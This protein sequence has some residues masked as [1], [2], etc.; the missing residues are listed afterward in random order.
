M[1]LVGEFVVGE[2]LSESGGFDECVGDGESV[3]IWGEW[4]DSVFEISHVA[5][6]FV[7]LHG[8]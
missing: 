3:W 6:Q 4:V 5:F 7:I 2:I 1:C 8:K